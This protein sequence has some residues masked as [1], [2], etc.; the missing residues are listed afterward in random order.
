MDT[1]ACPCGSTLRFAECCG[2]LLSG[3]RAASSAEQLMRSR[4]TAYVRLDR[5]YLEHTWH[6]TTR[7]AQL[8]LNTGPEPRWTGL[9]ILR[10]TAGL[11]SDSAGTV[12]F[13][14]RYKLNGRARRLHEVS[15][16]VQEH[17]RWFYLDGG[18]DQ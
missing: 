8:L 4:Y 10:T 6:P 5:A 7:P 18:V 11:A 13:E 1:E 17:G 3:E 2:P 12:E 14:A 9:K 15:R 16:F